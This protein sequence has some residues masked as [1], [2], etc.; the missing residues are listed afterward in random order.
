MYVSHEIRLLC[1][2]TIIVDHPPHNAR[3]KIL[4]YA[5]GMPEEENHQPLQLQHVVLTLLRPLVTVTIPSV[6][7]APKRG[8]HALKLNESM[9]LSCSW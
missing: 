5:N 3:A 9:V 4:R 7:P 8:L 6:R 1:Q 2:Y